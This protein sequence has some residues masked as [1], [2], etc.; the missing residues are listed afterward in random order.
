MF[1]FQVSAGIWISLRCCS[2]CFF[3]VANNAFVDVANDTTTMPQSP[4]EDG[5]KGLV[6]LLIRMLSL[7]L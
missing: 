3:D 7:V 2:R 6:Q 5:N 4:A 1:I